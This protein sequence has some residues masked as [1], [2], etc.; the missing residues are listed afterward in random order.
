MFV[1][2]ISEKRLLDLQA[3]KFRDL[4]NL[5]VN[6]IRSQ[7]AMLISGSRHYFYVADFCSSE[8]RKIHHVQKGTDY[9]NRVS[10]FRMH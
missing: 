10:L 6:V 9:A 5:N 1:K 3:L 4:T 8:I 7:D 2:Q